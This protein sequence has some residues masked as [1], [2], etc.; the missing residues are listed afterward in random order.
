MD[1]TSTRH[2]DAQ[3]PAP[4][5]W[6][7]AEAH[8]AQDDLAAWAY[9]HLPR[10]GRL[11]REDIDAATQAQ[12]L[13]IAATIADSAGTVMPTEAASAVSGIGFEDESA[14]RRLPYLTA[15]PRTFLVVVLVM[16]AAACAARFL[17]GAS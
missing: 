11:D 16:L 8:A 9:D 10:I 6:N 17:W 14:P 5:S 2:A 13:H 3:I 1:Q 12:R 4:S 15:K 7:K